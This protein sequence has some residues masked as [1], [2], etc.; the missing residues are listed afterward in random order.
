MP[1]P[2]RRAPEAGSLRDLQTPTLA[3]RRPF[4]RAGQARH[5]SLGN[6]LQLIAG[7][8]ARAVFLHLACDEDDR[9]DTR[10][11]SQAV[12][13]LSRVDGVFRATVVSVRRG[14]D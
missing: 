8:H 13:E 2:A 11:V 12:I 3:R 5:A 1:G 6:C 4:E 14:T 10:F 7:S 9:A